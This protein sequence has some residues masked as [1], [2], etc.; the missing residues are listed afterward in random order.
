MKIVI[1]G[2]G[3][4]GLLLAHRLLARSSHYQVFIY[5]Q[6]SDP[7][8]QRSDERAFVISLT[9][10]GQQI[11]KA[12]EGL[13]PVVKQQGV[14]IRKTG[15]Y[16]QK[17]G[18]WQSVQRSSDPEQF[19]LLINRN[20][21]CIA[22]LDELEKR[23]NPNSL[24][25]VFNAPC[26]EVDLKA[27]RVKFAVSED[28]PLEQSYDL[29]V[30]A[31]GIHSVVKNALL[32]QPGFDFQQSYFNSVWKVLH[33][34][35]P[36]ELAADTSYFFRR[37]FPASQS[38]ELPN[39]LS[40]AV[41]PELDDQLCLLMFWRQFPQLTQGNPPGIQTPEDLQKSVFEQWL[42]GIQLSDAAAQTFFDQ[43]PS[44]ILE[45]RCNRYHDDAGQAVLVGDAAHAMSSFL[46]QGCQAAFADVVALD[47]ALQ[48]ANDNLQV[49]LPNYSAI[50]VKEGH[51]ITDLN[52]LLNPQA[53]WVSLLFG[54]AMT[55]QSKL[56]QRF[57]RW[58]SPPPSTLLSKTTLPYTTIAD[59]FKPWLSLIQWS[60]QRQLPTKKPI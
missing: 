18:Q 34:P 32:K 53:K 17:L 20:N 16:N 55:I 19:S 25:L 22:L 10:R 30:G 50:Q 52:T 38:G 33:I 35:K 26:V 12:I 4:A 29:L 48:A 58:I 46:A 23:A 24:H 41:I 37:Q 8:I 56:S 14:E 45:T 44:S 60:N 7:R 40:G 57:P 49:A 21:L 27:H 5:D 6:R 13:W 15:F 42:P 31:D 39:Q 3:P 1:V 9:E 2:A 43:R 11:L 51:A 47:Q 54:I 59:R 28:H 36:P